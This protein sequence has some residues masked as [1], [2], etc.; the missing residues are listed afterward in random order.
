M[1]VALFTPVNPVRSAL[2]DHIEGLLPHLTRELDITVVTKGGYTPSHP[3]FHG[4]GPGQVPWI[5]YASLGGRADEFDLIIYQM[6]D[7]AEI[8]GYM[9]DA[10]ERW[11]GL[12]FLHD[13]VLHHAVVGRT[14]ARGDVA[15]YVRE[16]VYCYGEQGRRIAQRV[17]SGDDALLFAYPAAKRV[18]DQS[19]AAIGFNGYMCDQIARIR[20]DLPTHYI[21]YHFYLP[22]G[23]EPDF[24][25]AGLRQSLGLGDD[26]V[27]ASFGFFV[28]DK[29]LKLV[30]EAFK[31]VLR[32]HPRARYVLVGGS[33]PHYDLAGE[34]RSLGL[35]DRVQLT[36]WQAPAPFVRHMRLPD[37]AVHLRYP[38]IGGTL[39]TPIRLLGLGVPTITSD[40]EPLAEL[41]A[42]G[43]VRI[44]PN[45]PD[46]SEILS[47]AMDYL[48]TYPE[49]AQEMARRGQDFVRR[50][51]DLEAVARRYLS[52]IE[53]VA[54]NKDEL[55]ARVHRLAG[56]S[57]APVR[58]R[59]SL[60]QDAAQALAE[61]HV[62][63][64][65]RLLRP[66]ASAI[67]S[68]TTDSD[69]D[70]GAAS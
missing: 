53:G 1:R 47:A 40:I 50:E 63:T 12:L 46:E 9:F 60:T 27:I 62:P 45:V 16:L 66:V 4:H 58:R 13:L 64:S 8:H 31:R 15:G 10:L 36:G 41:P 57:P 65:P 23:L 26:P 69:R 11:P 59:W 70:Q 35:G 20:P 18:L 39:Y 34:L 56:R 54:A 51:H 44:A 38:H 28:P 33:S 21:P 61:L 17:M 6:G 5:D 52:V 32:R 30:L 49:V 43:V 24:D 29:R 37:V 19:L 25:D 67:A 2:S 55:T 48:L 3:M 7:E 42:D 68:L 14:L 22:K